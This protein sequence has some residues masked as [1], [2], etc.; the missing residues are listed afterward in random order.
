MPPESIISLLRWRVVN[1]VTGAEVI[2]ILPHLHQSHYV[3]RGMQPGAPAS[4]CIGEFTIPLAPPTSG[5]EFW[6]NKVIT[7]LLDYG[8]RVEAYRSFPGDGR[9]DAGDGV[10][11]SGGG[12]PGEGQLVFAGII[13]GIEKTLTKYEISGSSDVWLMHAS[14]CFPTEQ[15][16]YLNGTS[17]FFLKSYVGVACGQWNDS[18]S[19]YVAGN[20]ASLGGGSWAAT[21]ADNPALNC[22]QVSTGANPI[23]W[24]ANPVIGFNSGGGPTLPLPAQSMAPSAA[25]ATGLLT[26]TSTDVTNA[27][28]AGVVI[29]YDVNNLV[30]ARAILRYVVATALYNVDVIITRTVGGV[31]TSQTATGVMTGLP[32]E[33]GTMK[34]RFQIGLIMQQLVLPATIINVSN[35]FHVILNGL[36]VTFPAITYDANAWNQQLK[37]GMTYLLPATG[38]ATASF[39]QLDVIQRSTSMPFGGGSNG[40]F[41]MGNPPATSASIPQALATAGQSYLE[42]IQ[43][44]A[45]VE[46]Q[47]WRYTPNPSG[48]WTNVLTLGAIEMG[49]APGVDRSSGNANEVRFEETGNLIDV[50]LAANA[51]IFSSS[52]RLNGTPGS[53]GAA[54]LYYNPAGVAKYGI[55][56]DNVPS[57]AV[58]DFFA[59]RRYAAQI[60]A[61][62]N[63]VGVAKQIVVRRDPTTADVWRELDYITLHSPSAGLLN[64]KALV[65]AYDFTENLETQNIWL[66]QYGELDLMVQ[67]GRDQQATIFTAAQFKAR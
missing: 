50:A 8:L 18:F 37:A 27:G 7:D 40:Q 33:F 59:L 5:D 10:T 44:A 12:G 47:Y 23:L 39:F 31:S 14:K 63:K 61:L 38:A 30:Q 54:F 36:A 26:S 1:R 41:I 45:T 11:L 4:A 49:T 42:M 24:T 66:D 20:Y 21:T 52:M 19:P 13:R 3:V 53:Q 64:Y 6:K 56:E 16:S 32:A 57:L 46:G 65:I 48:G 29:G 55:L 60:G 34:F 22:V 67:E 9:G 15:T 35:E 62:R 43:M 28:E 51:E 58:S 25:Y 17:G 2:D